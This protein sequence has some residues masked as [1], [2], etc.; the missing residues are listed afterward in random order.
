MALAPD[1][2]AYS[3][4][5]DH[6]PTLVLCV[7]LLL[8]GARAHA[9]AADPALQQQ[10]RQFALAGAQRADGL[11]VEVVIGE[12][13]A[14]LHLAPC[15]EV[16]PYLPTSSRLWGRTR[17]GIR[18]VRGASRWNV[19]LP[20]TVKVWGT[21]LVAT[22]ALAVGT[23]I[24]TTDIAQAEVDLAEEATNALQRP[25]LAV[26]R[27]LAQAVAPGRSL[28][29]A[30][31]QPRRWFAAGETVRVIAQGSGF[32]VAGEGQALTPGTEGQVARVRTEG[33][34]VLSGTPVGERQVE[35]N[36]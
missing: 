26:G 19:Y 7:A 27:T 14:R 13:D 28:R 36:L 29:L 4:A 9:E 21:G 2:R 35:V 22:R 11:R 5:M 12:L 32:R 33:G 31:L 1:G 8:G 10:V 34:R 3:D 24:E 17:V 15:A 18:C 16:Q 25:E 23:V 30:H 6:W 20:V